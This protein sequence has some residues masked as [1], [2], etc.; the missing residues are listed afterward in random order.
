[1]AEVLIIRLSAIGD[2]AMTIPVV[3]SVAS[4]C[5][6]DTFTILTQSFL[7]S[8]FINRPPNVHVLGVNTKKIEKQSGGFLRFAYGLADRKYDIVLDLHYVIRSRIINFM[9][10]LKG[11]RVYLVDKKRKER[12]QLTAKPPKKLTPLSAVTDR[13]AEVFHRAGFRFKDTFSSLFVFDESS[14]KSTV[15]GEK[16]GDWIGI[17]PF[18][19]HVGKIYPI[20]EMEKT[21]AIL[22]NRPNT[23][24]YFFGGSGAE[25]AILSRWE[26]QFPNTHCV[27]GRYRLEQ[28]LE[29]ISH[30]DVLLS[31]DSANMHF[32][33]LVATKVVSIWGATHPYAGFYGYKQNPRHAVMVDLPCRPCSIYGNKPCYRKDY[34]CLKQIIPEVIIAKIEETLK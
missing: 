11:K 30:L 2:V 6:D 5:P 7:E 31:M 12:R 33:S 16:K 32:A 20:D 19:R 10:R 21:V 17:A 23:F 24:L 27:A 34:A 15:F 1:M 29:L 26:N 13:Y 4:A 18:A 25:S 22:S 8:L 9:F 3:Y 14:K 28:E